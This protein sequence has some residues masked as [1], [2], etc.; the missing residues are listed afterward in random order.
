MEDNALQ[1]ELKARLASALEY[2]IDDI[3]ANILDEWQDQDLTVLQARILQV[4]EQ[5]GPTRMGELATS[6]GHNLSAATSLI[7]RLV[8]KN[9]VQRT[10]DPKDRRVVVCELTT[11]GQAMMRRLKG[12]T[13]ETIAGIAATTKPDQMESLVQGLERLREQAD[14]NEERESPK[15]DR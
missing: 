3:Y 10:P 9:L 7:D 14:Q 11:G 13:E 4:L 5:Q 8:D 12:V 1:S 2:L 15:C 6:L